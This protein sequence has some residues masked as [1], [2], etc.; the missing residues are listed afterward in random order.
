MNVYMNQKYYNTKELMLQQEF[1][2]I[3]NQIIQKEMHDFSLLVF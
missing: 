3:I 1:T 2:L